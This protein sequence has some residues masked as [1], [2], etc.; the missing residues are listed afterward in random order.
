MKNIY[1]EESAR[2][3]KS[4]SNCGYRKF[5]IT[6]KK[7]VDVKASLITYWNSNLC[8]LAIPVHSLT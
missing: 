2:N 5:G 8:V 3:E 1:E 6:L 7:L 4:D